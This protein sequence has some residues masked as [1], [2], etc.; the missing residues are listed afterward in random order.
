MSV[1]RPVY[2]LFGALKEKINSLLG[3]KKVVEQFPQGNVEGW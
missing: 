3:A 2:P 1:L